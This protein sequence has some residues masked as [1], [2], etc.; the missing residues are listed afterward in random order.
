M[1]CT[2]TLFSICE[3]FHNL[4]PR[5]SLPDKD[6]IKKS[7]EDL[8]ETSMWKLFSGVV[9]EKKMEEFALACSFEQ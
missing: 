2:V 9:V 4:Q 1:I 8:N 7:Y 5:L 6:Y 3:G